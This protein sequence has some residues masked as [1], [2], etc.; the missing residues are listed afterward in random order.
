MNQQDDLRTP[1]MDSEAQ[2]VTTQ[3]E[4]TEIQ[5][6]QTVIEEPDPLTQLQQQNAELNDRYLRLM[7]EYD[8]FRKRTQREK[9]DLYSS[10]TAS[11][12]EKF[13]PVMD[14]FI[15]ASSFEQGSDDFKKG[16]DLIYSGFASVLEGLGVTPFGQPGDAFDPT[17]HNA[18]SH[19]EDPSLGNTVVSQVLQQ[20]YKMGDR[21][22]RC[23]MVQTAN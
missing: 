14:N 5:A 7:A 13:L 21:V 1:D 22:I 23:A 9:E 10:V 12:V 6:E 20:G 2:D 16:F 18:I 15:R 3:S 4:D 8:N 17:V 19:I 11:T